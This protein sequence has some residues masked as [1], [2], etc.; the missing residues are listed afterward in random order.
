MCASNGVT[1]RANARL[2][3][4]E[5]LADP[6]VQALMAADHLDPES[7]AALMRRMAH[8]ARR[9]PSLEP[10]HEWRDGNAR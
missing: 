7:V 6:I 2:T 1:D 3:I 9:A 4:P 5:A 10:R 8:L